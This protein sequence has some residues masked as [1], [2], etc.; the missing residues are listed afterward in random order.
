[1]INAWDKASPY[2]HIAEMFPLISQTGCSS[3]GSH[4]GV[5]ADGEDGD[6]YWEEEKKKSGFLC[7][8]NK[9][10]GPSG[11]LSG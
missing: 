6:H 9:R 3:T 2:I 10:K 5:L 4:A 8:Q 11:G 7:D 1:M